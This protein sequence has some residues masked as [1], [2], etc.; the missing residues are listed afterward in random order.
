MLFHHLF[1]FCIYKVRNKISHFIIIYTYIYHWNQLY[2]VFG[3]SLNWLTLMVLSVMPHVVMIFS[4]AF[5]YAVL[6]MWRKSKKNHISIENVK[7]CMAKILSQIERI[8]FL[9]ETVYV[10]KTIVCCVIPSINI[11]ICINFHHHF[12][13]TIYRI[14]MWKFVIR[15]SLKPIGKSIWFSSW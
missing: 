2:F 7:F 14:C 9:F 6:W 12:I 8:A 4:F 5:L 15:F 3:V 10:Q 1:F 13:V 11:H